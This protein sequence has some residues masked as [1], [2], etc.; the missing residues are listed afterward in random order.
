[1]SGSDLSRNRRTRILKSSVI[2]G[3]IGAAALPMVMLVGRMDSG[4]NYTTI[5]VGLVVAQPAILLC[6]MF[7]SSLFLSHS[8]DPKVGEMIV[9]LTI[10][11]DAFVGLIAGAVISC[12]AGFLRSFRGPKQV[13]AP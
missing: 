7:G 6:R 4:P 2:G 10:A 9:I 1:M 12:L 3:V 13:S 5:V 8:N 11:T